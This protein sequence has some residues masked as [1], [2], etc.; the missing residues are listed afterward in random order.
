MLYTT[1]GFFALTG[2]MIWLHL[3]GRGAPRASG[4]DIAAPGRPCPKCNAAVPQGSAFCPACGVPQQMFELVAAPT[5]AAGTKAPAS[6][7]PRA[8]VRADMCVGCGTCVASCPEPGA[9][10]MRGKLAVVDN[11]LCQ[12]HGECVRGCPVGAISVTTG[13]GTTTTRARLFAAERWCGRPRCRTAWPIVRPNSSRPR[14]ERG[15]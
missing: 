7:V 11:A 1:L 5:A 14:R 6:G 9:I 3:R 12:G 15:T 4:M 10:T 13:T 2:L 8:L